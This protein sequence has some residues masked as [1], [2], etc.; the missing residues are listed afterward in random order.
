LV[1]EFT[2]EIQASSVLL[3]K[4]CGHHC[5]VVLEQHLIAFDGNYG[6]KLLHN[7]TWL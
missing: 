1:V 6:A 4:P 7:H 3:E 5:G 2:D